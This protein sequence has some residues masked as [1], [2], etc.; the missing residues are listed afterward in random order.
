MSTNPPNNP[1][2]NG[3]A[4]P[5]NG[6]GRRA[7]IEPA[8]GLS[9]A[10]QAFVAQLQNEPAGETAIEFKVHG[11]DIQH[12]EI[13][14][15][16]GDAVIAENGAMIWKDSDIELS[17][18]LGDGANDKAGVLEKAGS[19]LR[20][21]IAG[22]GLYLSEF[23]HLGHGRKAKLALGAR[24]PGQIV[25][26][27]LDELGGTLV[28]RR[29]SFL[30]AAKGAKI[31]AQL[32]RN[33]LSGLLGSEGLVMQAITGSGWVFVNVGGNLIERDLQPGDMIHVDSGCHVGHEPSVD[34]NIRMAGGFGVTVAGDEGF[35]MTTLR[36]PGRVW[37][38]SLPPR[39]FDA[40]RSVAAPSIA[41]AAAGGMADG[42]SKVVT[43][44]GIELVKKLF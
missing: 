30:A 27:K 11:H 10:A 35:L 4:M 3:I 39:S 1:R 25:A 44:G 2:L 31:D 28:C 42:L 9:P 21:G 37:I 29:G 24:S 33:L 34:M 16:P 40:A 23:K 41:G 12:V 43:H 36:G 38:Q 8:G 20:T 19:M 6:F 18:V 22:E 5:S 15:E 14:L 7:A 26:I 13:E 32:Q 17:L